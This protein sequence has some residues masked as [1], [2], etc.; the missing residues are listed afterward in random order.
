MTVNCAQV[1]LG[2]WKRGFSINTHQ[3]QEIRNCRPSMNSLETNHCSTDT[4]VLLAKGSNSQLVRVGKQSLRLIWLEPVT[5]PYKRLLNVGAAFFFALV[6]AIKAEYETVPVV[7]RFLRAHV[8]RSRESGL[9]LF[10]QPRRGG[11]SSSYL[12]AVQVF[13]HFIQL[14][15]NLLA[16][17]ELK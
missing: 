15:L 12:T 4:G 2:S 3:T 11:N 1:R 10:F 16:K 13:Y 5:W 7:W 9:S 8:T 14:A 6:R 17:V